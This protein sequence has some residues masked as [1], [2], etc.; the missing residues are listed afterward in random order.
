M[1]PSVVV[2]SKCSVTRSK[3]GV[4]VLHLGFYIKKVGN[5]KHDTVVATVAQ[6]Y[7]TAITY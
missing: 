2:E 1:N 4:K 6:K 3:K 7:S 5:L